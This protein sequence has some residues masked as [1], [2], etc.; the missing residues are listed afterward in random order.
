MTARFKAVEGQNDKLNFRQGK[1]L[2]LHKDFLYLPPGI[3]PTSMIGLL[4][5]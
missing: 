2:G 5:R 1:T 3:I 4:W